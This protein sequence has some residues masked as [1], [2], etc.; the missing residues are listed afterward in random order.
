MELEMPLFS[1]LTLFNNL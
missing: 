1:I